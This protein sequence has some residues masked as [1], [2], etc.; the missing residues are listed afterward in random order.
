[1]EKTR[2]PLEAALKVAQHIEALL[3]PTCSKIMIVGSV[4]RQKTTVGDIEILYIPKLVSLVP[5]G[6]MFPR[7]TIATDLVIQ[8]LLRKGELVKR[9]KVNGTLT[10]GQWNKLTTHQASGIPVDLF[11]TTEGAWWNNL[12]ARTG[13]KD[14]NVEIAKRAIRRGLNWEMYGNGFVEQATGKITLTTS[15]EHIFKI[16]NLPYEP[17]EKR[18]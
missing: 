16:V 13:G 3:L 17:P 10:F 5:D 9:P 12:V 18:K 1:V 2:H 15:E 7:P 4:R 6:E 14:T 8:D 11:A